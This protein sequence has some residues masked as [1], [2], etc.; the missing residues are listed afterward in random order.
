[1]NFTSGIML[2][3]SLLSALWSSA[4]VGEELLK[5]L[6]KDTPK[7]Q[8][9]NYND[10][11]SR[12]MNING[13]LLNISS[14][15][16]IITGDYRE[17][18]NTICSAGHKSC[19]WP[20]SHNKNIYVPYA[21]KSNYKRAHKALIM[22]SLFEFESLT[23]LRFKYRTREVAYLEFIDGIG[24]WSYVGP[25][26]RTQ[27]ISL[28]EPHCVDVGIIQHQMMHALGFYHETSRTD[29]KNHVEVKIEHVVKGFEHNFNVKKSNNLVTE[30]DYSSIMHFGRY[31][32]S[33]MPGLPTIVP[34]PD[35]NINLGQLMG[36]SKTDILKINK[37]YQ[38]N[39]CGNLLTENY[40]SFISPHYPDLYPDYAQCKWMIRAPWQHKIILEFNFFHIQIYV[41]CYRDNLKI[42]DGSTVHSRILKGP[43]CGKMAPAVISSDHQLLIVFVSGHFKH[44]KGFSAKYRFVTCGRM[45]IASPTKIIGKFEYRATLNPNE[46]SNCFW[47]VQAHKGHKVVFEITTY[48]FQRS[49]NCTNAYMKI[50]D[51]ARAPPTSQGKFCEATPIPIVEGTALLLEFKH[52]GAQIQPGLRVDYKCVIHP[53]ERQGRSS[54]HWNQCNAFILVW[55]ILLNSV[56]IM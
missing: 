39:V 31:A 37:L 35:P 43:V 7:A 47:L 56:W 6:F 17:H 29:R 45:L 20:S 52:P 27:E 26:K 23:C 40:G 1:M 18:A 11:I 30:Y 34:K 21:F 32:F 16:G 54:V 10:I 38:C 19:L 33:K 3:F 8:E 2:A 25:G 14:L 51:V 28:Q 5:Q 13:P 48:N 49:D 50:H 9:M 22:T 36:F 55:C 53:F 24:C 42:Y 4:V 41:G 12:I 44:S 46:I 15:Q